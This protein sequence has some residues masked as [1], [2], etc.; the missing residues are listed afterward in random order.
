MT[1]HEVAINWLQ[2]CRDAIAFGS[3]STIA[4][5]TFWAYQTLDDLCLKEPIRALKIVR[6]IFEMNPEERVISNLS[7][8][9]LEDILVRHGVELMP[10][11]KQCLRENKELSTLLEGV[12]IN[13]MDTEVQLALEEIIKPMDSK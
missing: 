4:D 7:A 5:K 6:E 9:P 13:G 3:D 8:G 12:W 10:Y 1:D 2:N 11:L